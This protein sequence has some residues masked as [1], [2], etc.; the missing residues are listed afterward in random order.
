MYLI[1]Q[2]ICPKRARAWGGWKGR[3]GGRGGGVHD[4]VNFGELEI[5]LLTYRQAER[6]AKNI[7]CYSRAEIAMCRV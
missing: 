5:S 6:W 7:T 4:V 3:G 1:V 2:S